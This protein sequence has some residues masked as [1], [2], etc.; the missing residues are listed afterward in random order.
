MHHALTRHLGVGNVIMRSRGIEQF[1]GVARD[2]LLETTALSVQRTIQIGLEQRRFPGIARLFRCG[3]R[4]QHGG[5]AL[6]GPR[7]RRILRRLR[8][9]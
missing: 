4:A 8:V 9:R 2:S 5:D 3:G 1:T 7:G 6:L